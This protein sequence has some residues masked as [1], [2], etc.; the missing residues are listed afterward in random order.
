MS[1]GVAG[2]WENSIKQDS[3]HSFLD[4]ILV[5]KSKKWKENKQ[6]NQYFENAGIY[7]LTANECPSNNIGHACYKFLVV[8]RTFSQR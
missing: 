6:N 4:R 7:K 5:L 2:T 1:I 3:I 8:T